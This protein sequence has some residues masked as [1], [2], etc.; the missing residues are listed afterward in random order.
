MWENYPKTWKFLIDLGIFLKYKTL[1]INK[2]PNRIVLPSSNVLYV[3]SEENRGRALLISSGMTQKRLTKFWRQAVEVNDPDLVIDVGVNYG[4]CIFSTTYPQHAEI[5]GIEANQHL[6]KYIEQ[7][8]EVHPN[9]TQINIFHAFAADKDDEDKLFFVDKHWSG[10]SS[11]AYSPNHKM[12]EKVPVKSITI[13]SLIKEDVQNKKVLFKVD[14][15]GYEAFVL[16]GMTELFAKSASAIGFIEFN[17]EY[18]EKAGVDVNNFIS[19]LH[20][21][22]TIYIYQEDDQIVK[23]SDLTY[24]ELKNMFGTDYIH[25]D[26]IL[27]TDEKLID[28]LGLTIK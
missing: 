7:S 14:V 9:K 16:K 4:E 6:H 28:S 25:T 15:E 27:A 10:T 19:F 2:I 22:F 18:I 17:S 23:A 24:K 8:R 21:Y 11:A 13:D 1:N 5:Y 26:M 3:N 20:Q 12:I